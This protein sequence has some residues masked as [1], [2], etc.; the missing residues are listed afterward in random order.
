MECTLKADQDSCLSFDWVWLM[1]GLGSWLAQR[2]FF[3]ATNRA[4][5]TFY[6]SRSDSSLDSFL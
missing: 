6:P 5:S 1:I 2:R 3:V 4:I